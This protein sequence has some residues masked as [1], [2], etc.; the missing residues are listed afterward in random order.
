MYSSYENI[1]CDI[2]LNQ[3]IETCEFLSM[4]HNSIIDL[5]KTYNKN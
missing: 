5:T 4:N 2:T 3:Q 1:V